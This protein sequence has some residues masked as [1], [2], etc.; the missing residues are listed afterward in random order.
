MR[1][2]LASLLVVTILFFGA[3]A[4]AEPKEF[5]FDK[6]H[7]SILFRIS[8]GGFSDFIGEFLE[9]DGKVILDEANPANSSVEVTIRPE[10]IDTD[11]PDFDKKLQDKNFFNT[12]EFPEAKFVSNEV[13]MTGEN[14][15]IV[16]GDF[17]MLGQTHPITLDVT[18]NKIDNDV[19]RGTYKAGFSATA[20]IDRTLW[21]LSYG[22]PTIGSHVS[23]II[24]T[25]VD[26]P[27]DN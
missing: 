19:W 25:E 6:S 24:E 9:Y 18:L 3:E 15:A 23:I 16:H 27:Q 8:H 4:K 26:R 20:V 7:T 10:G 11:L 22:A 1:R 13:E 5:S 12:A 14:T 2:L 17:T 21:D